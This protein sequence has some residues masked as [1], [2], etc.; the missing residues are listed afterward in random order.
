MCFLFKKKFKRKQTMNNQAETLEATSAKDIILILEDQE[1][2]IKAFEQWF[3]DNGLNVELLICKTYP[4]YEKN[5]S[6]SKINSRVKCIIMDL[7]NNK[8]EETATKYKSTEYIKEQYHNNRIP[9]FIHSGFLENFTDLEDKGTVFKIP[10]DSTSIRSIGDSIKLMFES[11]FLNIFSFGGSIESKIMTEIHK[12]FLDQFKGKEIEEI[13]KSIKVASS[14]NVNNRTKEVFER[15]ALR[16][17][18]QNAISNKENKESVKVNSI[19]HYYRRTGSD[20]HLFW[21]GD[22]F[23]KNT[24]NGVLE[25]VFIATPRCNISNKNFESVLCFKINLIREDQKSSFLSTKI[26]NKDTGETK[27]SKQ[28]RTSITDDSTNAF[29][30][31][32][33][34]FLPKTPQFDGGFVD[35]MKCL[36]IE[37]EELEKGYEYVI[38]LVDD[39]TNDV[40]RKAATYL[41]R[42]GISDTEYNEALYYFNENAVE[43]PAKSN[44]DM[45]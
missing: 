3:E 11:G 25:L 24:T 31:E 14:E 30:G 17:V 18:Y 23:K 13:I 27:G 12:A 37:I 2:V 4:E 36:T 40:V 45:A 33:F 22:I 9:I 8:E 43:S 21:T 32:R 20:K 6:D 10:K 35:C 38:S 41:Q 44:G 34:R 1:T 39:L 28:L 19:E 7:S 5:I 42:G 16:A 29:V 26:D 15:L